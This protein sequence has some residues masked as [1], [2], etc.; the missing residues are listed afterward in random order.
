MASSHKVL[1]EV[2]GHCEMWCLS[3]R[4]AL[5]RGHAAELCCRQRTMLEPCVKWLDICFEAHHHFA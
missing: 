5:Q 1:T 4:D 3:S 2:A